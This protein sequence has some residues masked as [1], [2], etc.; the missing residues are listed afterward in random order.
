MLRDPISKTKLAREAPGSTV[1]TSLMPGL[2]TRHL[3]GLLHTGAAGGTQALPRAHT[4]RALLTEA[5]PQLEGF[6]L[7]HSL[8][9]HHAC[10]HGPRVLR[11]NTTAAGMCSGGVSYPM[12]GRKQRVR[13]EPPTNCHIQRH[14]PVT[15]SSAPVF[16]MSTGYKTVAPGET[17]PSTRDH[18]GS[19]PME[20]VSFLFSHG[21]L[22]SG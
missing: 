11:Q 12:T 15:T 4:A 14:A 8:R 18:M 13:L 6:L 22:S 10:S 1:P 16:N 3:S 20:A 2:H 17:K 5:S 19:F 21:H 7:L 9:G